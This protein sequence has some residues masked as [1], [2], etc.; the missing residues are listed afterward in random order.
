VRLFSDRHGFITLTRTRRM[1]F[2]T[3]RCSP[4]SS[5][6]ASRGSARGA[7]GMSPPSRCKCVASCTPLRLIT[8]HVFCFSYISFFSYRS[9]YEHYAD[10]ETTLQTEFELL[11]GDSIAQT[12]SMPC[13]LKISFLPDCVVFLQ[14]NFRKV[15]RTHVRWR[16][17]LC[18]ISLCS[19]CSS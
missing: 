9:E 5:C 11:F 19:S 12:H 10:F 7:S 14:V 18:C 2:F 3:R 4:P 8:H 17:L 6:C 13:Y 16:R 15:G 1:T